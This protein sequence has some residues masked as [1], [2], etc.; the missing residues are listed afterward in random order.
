MQGRSA[1]W[2][3][4]PGAARP[5]CRG[6]RGCCRPCL[7]APGPGFRGQRACGSAS[8]SAPRCVG[9]RGH[10]GLLCLACGLPYLGR[11]PLHGFFAFFFAC[12]LP[13][14]VHWSRRK[15]VFEVFVNYCS[16]GFRPG[17]L[18]LGPILES[19]FLWLCFCLQKPPGFF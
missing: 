14:H 1:G 15:S 18:P 8:S 13:R 2:R 3:L 19:G 6:G 4:G 11:G 9:S 17:F 10:A 7:A 12:S 5:C 16:L